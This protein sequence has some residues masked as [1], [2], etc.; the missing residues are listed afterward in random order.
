MDLQTH[1]LFQPRQAN[2]R[3]ATNKYMEIIPSP[4]L[5]SYVSCY[6]VSEPVTENQQQDSSRSLNALREGSV[7]RVLPDGCS[8]IIF[9]H[10]LKRNKYRTLF[11]GFIDEPFTITYDQH[12]PLRKFG[13]RFFPGGIYSMLGIPQQE[14]ANSHVDIDLVWASMT[15]EIE[16]R[17][18]EETSFE[19]KARIM[20]EYLLSCVRTKIIANDN[21][22][23]NLLYHI[24][25]T[26]GKK[27]VRELASKEAISTRQMNR[28][29]YRWIGT[30]PKRFCEV[31][32]FQSI[33]NVIQSSPVIDRT[34]AF[35]HGYFDQAHMIRD[36][37]RFYGDSLSVAVREFGNMSDFYNK[38]V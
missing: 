19:K 6:W 3:V 28:I 25:V 35:N 11:C 36:F 5:N 4:L 38:K 33:V 22:I 16:A 15:K 26:E 17:I 23:N 29:F 30:S 1:T 34:L 20:D 31:V 12:Y 14:F 10:D 32:R 9:E 8:D 7:D 27:S 13:V 37:K 18:F 21:L 2:G 24:F